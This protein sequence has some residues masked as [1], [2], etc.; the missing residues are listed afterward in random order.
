[1]EG[2]VPSVQLR[3]VIKWAAARQSEL[4]EAWER[5]ERGDHP[6]QIAPPN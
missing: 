2:D 5:C 6:G 4:L 3:R 1:M